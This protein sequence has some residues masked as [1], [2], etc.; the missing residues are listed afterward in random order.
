MPGRASAWG[1]TGARE[2]ILMTSSRRCSYDLKFDRA[3]KHLIDL[4]GEVSRYCA[5]H[6]YAVTQAREGKRQKAAEAV[7]RG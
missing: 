4:E 5:T 7:S 3:E 2:V 1:V 6:P